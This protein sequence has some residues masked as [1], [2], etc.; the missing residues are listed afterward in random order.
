MSHKKKAAIA[1]FLFQT[2]ILNKLQEQP[3][4]TT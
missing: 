1:A 2:D 4:Q 3:E